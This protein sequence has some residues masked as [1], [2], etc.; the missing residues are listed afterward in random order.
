MQMYLIKEIFQRDHLT[1]FNRC[2]NNNGVGIKG[3]RKNLTEK[4]KKELSD[5]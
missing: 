5:L 1:V 2:E 4:M 3:N